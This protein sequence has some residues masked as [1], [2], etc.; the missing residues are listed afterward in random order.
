MIGPNRVIAKDVKK[1][2][3]CCNMRNIYSMIRGNA[4]PQ[5]GAQLKLTDKGH[6]IKRLI[7]C[8]LVRLGL[9]GG[10]GL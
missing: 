3:Y 5:K 8:Y 2:T 9:D 6:I 7:V 1:Y 4:I 10:K